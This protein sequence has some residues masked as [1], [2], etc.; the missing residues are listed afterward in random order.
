M[1][2]VNGPSDVLNY[3]IPVGSII[4]QYGTPGNDL[5]ANGGYNYTIVWTSTNVQVYFTPVNYNQYL[6]P[7]FDASIT[8]D[9][10]GNINSA[11]PS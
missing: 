2:G 4:D 3:S 5:Y 7:I 8:A 11:Y 1:G 6:A 9:T 10:N